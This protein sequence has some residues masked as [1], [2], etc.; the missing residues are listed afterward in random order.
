MVIAQ[1]CECAYYYCSSIT[2]TVHFKMIKMTNFI[3]QLFCH[4]EKYVVDKGLDVLI[5]LVRANI[6]FR[7]MR[8]GIDN[9]G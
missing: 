7:G 9:H 2:I 6:I 3:I 1:Q 4:S 8:R 5:L